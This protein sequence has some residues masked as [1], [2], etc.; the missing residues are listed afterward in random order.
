MHICVRTVYLGSKQT[1]KQTKKKKN[2]KKKYF[3][4]VWALLVGGDK[5]IFVYVS[6]AKFFTVISI[7]HKQVEWILCSNSFI[8]I[9]I[10]VQEISIIVNN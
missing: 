7:I 3:L 8:D 4:L 6:S 10:S 2:C 1:N 5:F 9:A